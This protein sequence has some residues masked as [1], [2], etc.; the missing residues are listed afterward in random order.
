MT[1][2]YGP[3]WN[4]HY[5]CAVNRRN[6][7]GIM[8]TAWD[9]SLLIRRG[10]N[11]QAPTVKTDMIRFKS[12]PVPLKLTRDPAP[13]DT[14]KRRIKI[15]FIKD[16]LL[17]RHWCVPFCQGQFIWCC[18]KFQAA[19]TTTRCFV[20]RQEKPTI[21][22]MKWYTIRRGTPGIAP[23]CVCVQS[24]VEFSFKETN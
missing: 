20:V 6:D 24:T 17:Y 9:A 7:A 13:L 12:E 2:H 11:S 8:R 1:A 4:F 21:S 5:R 23:T 14:E 18:W 16:S 22:S 15:Y 19:K 10:Q 3:N